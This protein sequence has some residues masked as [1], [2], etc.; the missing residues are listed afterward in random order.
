MSKE[1]YK[2]KDSIGYLIF[3]INQRMYG[4]FREKLEKEGINV[5]EAWILLQIFNDI[6]TI[7]K[8]K[9][10]LKIDMAQIHR[11]C[12]RLIE[13]RWIERQINPYD[14][15][16]KFLSL[17]NEGMSLIKRVVKYSKEINSKALSVISEEK[18]DQLR[19]LLLEICERNGPL[20]LSN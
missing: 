12:E 8:I 3:I 2:L 14:K 20:I 1:S 9:D 6:K 11:S 10:I 19:S 4:A 18:T 7:K 16:E 5:I 15:R 17:T 13:K